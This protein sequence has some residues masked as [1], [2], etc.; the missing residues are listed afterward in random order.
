MNWL[1][2][3]VLAVLVRYVFC[4]LHR[5]MVRT[6]FSIF[7]VLMTLLLTNILHP[8][9]YEVLTEKTQVYEIVREK[10]EENITQ[11]LEKEMDAWQ[12][13]KGEQGKVIDSLPLPERFK[14]ILI[15]NNHEEGYRRLLAKNFGEYLSC[16]IAGMIVRAVSIF[17]VFIIVS[18]FMSVL[19]GLLN[20]I[21]SLPVLTLMNKAGGSGTG[22]CSGDFHGVDFLSGNRGV[23]GCRMGKRGGGNAS[24]KQNHTV[25]V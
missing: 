15:E 12:M 16:S 10:C 11:V 19:G 20:R 8:Y 6:A 14:E 25:F 3:L 22:V 5:G 17:T 9:V 24:R 7:S 18:V 1:C 23:C 13:D 2:V 4:G 21:F